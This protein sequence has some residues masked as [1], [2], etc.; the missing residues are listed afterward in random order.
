[1]LRGAF[2]NADGGV[3]VVTPDPGGRLK[4]ETELEHLTRVM[5]QALFNAG[6][7]NAT[8][9]PVQDLP[10]KKLREAWSLI[11]DGLVIDMPKAKE[12]VL[13]RLRKKRDVELAAT[14]AEFV[15]L[16]ELDDKPELAKLKKKRKDL[17]DKA[18][19]VGNKTVKELE[20]ML[21]DAEITNGNRLQ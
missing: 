9:R 15:R 1:M 2:V 13:K 8:W 11:F 19:N 12:A 10:S 4:S 18:F 5:P 14:D 3:S 21:D 16:T 17:R 20:A 6:V 7:P